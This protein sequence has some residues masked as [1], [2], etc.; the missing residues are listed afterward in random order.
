MRMRRIRLEGLGYYHVI[1]RLVA[2]APRFDTFD[3]EQLRRW[4]RAYETFS[5][6]R[7]LTYA[8]LGSHFHILL[9]VPDRVE[10]DE[11]EIIRR[12][13]A[14]YNEKQ[15]RERLT[16]WEQWRRQGLESLVQRELDGLRRRMYDLS[17]F[18]KTLKQRFTQ[19]YNHRHQRRGTLWEDRFKSILVEASEEALSTVGAYI[20][21]N[22]LRAGL[23][24]DPKDYRW[25]GYA[26]ALGGNPQ[27]RKG[28]QQLMAPWLGEGAGWETVRNAYRVHL[29]EQGRRREGDGLGVGARAGIRPDV[30]ERVLSGNGRL[31]RPELLRCRVRYFSDGLALGSRDF[32]N[33]VFTQFRGNFGPRRKNGARALRHGDWGGLCAARDLMT[34]PITAPRGEG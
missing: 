1:S 12:M 24:G 29:Y 32:V 27:A 33:N 16:Q 6:V 14:I 10:I 15:L 9:E 22:P 30:V 7:V 20:D 31:S 11:Q 2:G 4:M 19:G 28:L 18:M 21:L 17:E 23:V 26:E 5:G 34:A 25:S 8:I 3:K 13:G